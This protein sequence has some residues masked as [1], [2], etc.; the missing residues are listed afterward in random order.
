MKVNILSNKLDEKRWYEAGI[1]Y[2]PNNIFEYKKV[3]S[4]AFVFFTMYIRF[5]KI[6]NN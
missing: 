4:I 5:D 6:K 1:S 2:E 3:I